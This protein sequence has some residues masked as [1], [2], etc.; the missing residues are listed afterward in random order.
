MNIEQEYVSDIQ[1]GTLHWQLHWK[2]DGLQDETKRGEKVKTLLHTI[3]F[4]AAFPTIDVETLTL[5]E[6]LQ[7]NGFH[8]AKIQT[9]ESLHSGIEFIWKQIEAKQRIVQELCLLNQN[10]FRRQVW[11]TI[12]S[13]YT[14]LIK[15][16]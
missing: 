4:C 2:Y 10:E 16:Q 9:R 8:D 11:L 3:R 15:D 7:F 12:P 1:T 14:D 13:D 5:E 6:Q